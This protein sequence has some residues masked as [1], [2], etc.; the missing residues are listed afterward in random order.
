MRGAPY[1]N[2]PLLLLFTW[3]LTTSPSLVRAQEDALAFESV[4]LDE[5]ASTHVSCILQDRTGFIWIAAWSGLYRY[6][7]YSFVAYKHNS[8]D[9]SSIADNLLSTLYEDKAGNLWVG[10]WLGLEKFD[11]V[12][13]TF[14]HFT[15]NPPA[16]RTDPSNNVST[17]CE[18][19]TGTLWVGSWGGVYCFDKI[20]EK[21][22]PVLH[23]SSNP[24]S[25]AHNSV[26]AIYESKDGS[27][28]L[29]TAAGLDKYDFATGKFQHCLRNPEGWRAMAWNV[30][31]AYWITSIIEDDAGVLWLGTQ[32][33]LV[34]Y[35]PGSGASETYRYAPP[36]P[37]VW[38]NLRNSI[39][40]LCW[41]AR[42]SSLWVS[43]A[44][45]LFAFEKGS[46][47]FLR[48]MEN[49]V[50]SL[51]I[52]RSG[53]LL[54]GTDTKLEKCN[55]ASPPFRKC[56][57]GD[58]AFGAVV[59][60]PGVVWVCGYSRGWQK[61]DLHQR[62]F[63]PHSFGRE[64]LYFVYQRERG[65]DMVFLSPDG[66][67]NTRD[68]LGRL[69]FHLGPSTKE[70]NISFS[71]AWHGP[72]GYYVGSHSGCVYF[73][74]P[75]DNSV[76]EILNLNQSISWM[77]EDTLGFLWIVTIMGRLV[78]Y[79]M[80]QATATEFVANP[81]DPA[82]WSGK[83]VNWLSVDSKGRL[84]FATSDGLERLDPP[85]NSF[86]QITEKD[87]LLSN[88]VRG[89]AEDDHGFLWVS[90]T[91]GIS[92]FDPETGRFKHY[93]A[94]YGLEPAADVLMG[95]V[96]KA[97]NGEML[98][99]GA[100]GVTVFH[101][102]SIRDNRFI[103][104]VVITSFRKFDRPSP[105][106]KEV[107]LSYDENFLSFEFAALSYISPERNQ[108][109]YMMEGIDRDWVHSGS[110]RY[111][112]YTNLP[113]GKYVFRV[114]GSNN[115]GVWNEAGISVAIVISPPW[116]KSPWAYGFY[117]L[118]ILSALYAT[119]RMQMR[120]VRIHHEYEMSRFEA[121]KLHEV[122]ELKSRF[123]ANI[124][125]EFRTPLTLIL[126][127][128]KRMQDASE[129][130]QT[131]DDLGVVHKNATR[132][133]Q[134]VNQLLDLSRLE[135][136]NMKL[137]TA[138]EN[139][140]PLLKGLFQAFCSYAERK[141]ISMAFT[142]SAESIV[143]WIDRD[144]VQKIIT[145]ILAN[146]F[147]FTPE[148]GRI[149]IS[150]AQDSQYVSV[151]IS[152]TGI[153]IPAETIPR[154]FDRFYQV[155]GSH[156]R[157]QEGTGIGL[158]LTRELVELHKGTIAVESEEGQGTTFTV[159]L[160]LGKAHLTEEEVCEL[161][162]AETKE[163]EKAAA[164]PSLLSDR[165][166]SRPGEVPRDSLEETGTP[167]LLI[168]EDNG[169]VRQYIRRDLDEEYSIL[170]AI[171]GED[172]WNKS[173]EHMP[174]VIVSDVM[175]PKM[176]GFRLCDKLKT[177]ER[178]SHIPVILLTAKASSEDKIEGFETGADDYIMKPF[179]PDEVKARIRNLIEQ[180]KRIHDYFKRRG[181]LDLDNPKI[182]SVDKKF[183]QKAF[184]TI[185][186]NASETSFDVESLAENLA[187]SRYVLYKKTVSLTGESPVELI[188]RIR[189][190]KAAEL[191][192]QK[193]GNISE[194]AIEVGYNN[195]AYFSDCFKRQFGVSPSHYHP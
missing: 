186:H 127:P 118:A 5:G 159:R 181:I 20:S 84:W 46:R 52:D 96:V 125:H 6:D 113:P 55:V 27:L 50:T 139:I 2:R 111:A 136:G 65:G 189:L 168:V 56:P 34:A 48:R 92:R 88:N 132:L 107:R 190:N 85:A 25:I 70:F 32:G 171:D 117:V 41:D 83:P 177:D 13:G 146:A 53:T 134:L 114:K 152:D 151:R 104:P 194:I 45:G 44:N 108:Y 166:G 23:D 47:T 37:E 82:S 133:L 135:S 33:G 60:R 137:Q 69:K 153:G 40:S 16:P 105:L 7:G 169:D 35:D 3:F 4:P 1:G 193:F 182:T 10:S 130:Q 128:V 43:T 26:G 183:L 129:D 101:P 140:V 58:I 149:E 86:T 42:T 122:D 187:V 155:D 17:I 81:K 145:N 161:E 12:T 191:I 184:D 120:R 142:S 138:P 31:S 109:A 165:E 91:K 174:D 98:F 76:K 195:P 68:T 59:G 15:P 22:T 97:S 148:G 78:R 90:T 126:G 115:E 99:G 93:D 173:I 144:K 63:V 74:D 24:G 75:R 77:T 180:R 39:R 188:R 116:W 71:M 123:F 38:P 95:G 67:A 176:D 11:Q 57:M 179:E 87:G 64:Q 185:T 89:V 61:F 8:A 124:S 51:C 30:I 106:P 80:A 112:S 163:E 175:M 29:G 14:R 72:K 121:A 18:D 192:Q 103:P 164:L 154:I 172:G 158:S 156:T 167:V 141:R 28:W 94:S 21:L 62:R 66:S 157:E 73:F 150:V 36:G 143:V 102:D 54:L 100:T 79:D 9:T 19:K 178:T 147:K 49:A 131:R 170:E 160:A 119:W 162:V 110:R